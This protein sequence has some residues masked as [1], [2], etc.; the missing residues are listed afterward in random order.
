MLSEMQMKMAN[1]RIQCNGMN[2]QW[3]VA[4]DLYK[5]L[6]ETRIVIPRELYGRKFNLSEVLMLDLGLPQHEN[7]GT[8]T[9]RYSDWLALLTIARP[10]LQSYLLL[11]VSERMS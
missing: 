8:V 11:M 2:M 6:E 9:E 10:L 7:D 3:S 4:F 5:E 1:E